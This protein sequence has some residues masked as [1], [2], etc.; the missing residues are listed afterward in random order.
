MVEFILYVRDQ[1]KSRDFYCAALN[2]QPT[3]DVPGMTEFL[4]EENVTLGLMPESGI[5]KII[6]PVTPEPSFGHGIPRC[7]LYLRVEDPENYL[8]R[9]IAAGAELIS[10]VSP[11]DW[12][13]EVG[14]CVDG[15]GHVLA[16]A[17]KS[18]L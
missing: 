16:F 10:K 6:C 13:D 5:R 7:E 9:S 4:L 8:E 14:Y 11:R 15:N 12:G 18:F 17:R 3:L 2:L 1:S